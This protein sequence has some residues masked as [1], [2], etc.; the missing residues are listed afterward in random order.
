[1]PMVERELLALVRDRPDDDAPRLVYADF[2]EDRGRADRAALIRVQCERARTRDCDPRQLDLG[3]Q[4]W[5]LFAE[6]GTR[7][8]RELPEIP[9]LIWA[10]RPYVRGLPAIGSVEDAQFWWEHVE[11][12]TE[13]APGAHLSVAG[14]RVPERLPDSWLRGLSVELDT[15]DPGC[16]ERLLDGPLAIYLR[17]L[18][19]R[20]P[21]SAQLLAAARQLTGLVLLYLDVDEAIV[22][23]AGASHLRSV[24]KLVL[25]GSEADRLAHGRGGRVDRAWAETLASP[26]MPFAELEHLVLV[27]QELQAT[28]LATVLAAPGLSRLRALELHGLRNRR[29]EPAPPPDL[30]ASFR[31]GPMRLTT[32]DVSGSRLSPE[33]LGEL[34]ALP[35]VAAL[36][37]L[38]LAMAALH[39]RLHGDVRL[40]RS[41]RVLELHH[42][43]LDATDLF[44]LFC[45]EPLPE[46]RSLDLAV[47]PIGA[48][49]A[50]VLAGAQLGPLAALDLLG[51]G[52]GDEGLSALG[53]AAFASSLRVLVLSDNSLT[54]AGLAALPTELVCLDLWHNA[55]TGKLP[56]LAALNAL[57]E[58]DV[59][60]GG[61]LRGFVGALRDLRA[62]LR[63]L[64][65]AGAAL[66][67]QATADLA[68]APFAA[69]LLRLSLNLETTT[70]DHSALDRLCQPGVFPRLLKLLVGFSAA[71]VECRD[72]LRHSELDA[73][74][75]HSR[76]TVPSLCQFL[77]YGRR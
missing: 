43:G 67:A 57:V 9:G 7:W 28:D 68:T 23:L 41:L 53:S 25:G 19:L 16:L 26:M 20:A 76:A 35:Q 29:R 22:D 11:T 33:C 65:I 4:E 56:S 44:G 72:R 73:R 59:G 10:D 2:L 54:G 31:S 5:C 17:A 32:L 51:C 34:L 18:R 24:R 55:L 15:A 70:A 45:R 14:W 58:L 3:V 61:D 63:H 60:R 50:R 13:V 62:P 39:D 42:N 66:D 37:K 75:D 69:G 1:M 71:G 6:H 8:R 36:E 21:R 30:H 38:D 77:G 46:L 48:A 52:V 40:P 74:L 47:N 12:L 27:G 64:N 49:G